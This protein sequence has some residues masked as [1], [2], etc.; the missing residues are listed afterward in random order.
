MWKFSSLTKI[1]DEV[2]VY[3]VADNVVNE[4]FKV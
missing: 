4:Y 2:R 3:S 1:E